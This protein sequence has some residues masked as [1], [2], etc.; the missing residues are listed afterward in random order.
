MEC[1]AT[2]FGAYD[3]PSTVW[4]LITQDCKKVLSEAFWG[5]VPTVLPHA[6]VHL[7]DKGSI[8]KIQGAL[9]IVV[10]HIIDIGLERPIDSLCS[11]FDFAILL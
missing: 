1:T 7:L 5:P 2:S 8:K 6:K 11:K 4:S 10:S 3:E 9:V